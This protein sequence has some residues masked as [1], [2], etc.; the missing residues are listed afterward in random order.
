MR[1]ATPVLATFAAALAA[2]VVAA[3]VVRAEPAAQPQ[4]G[5]P[6]DA[7]DPNAQTYAKAR[8]GTAEPEVLMCVGFQGRKWQAVGG[9]QRPVHDFYTY[10]PTEILYPGDVNLGEFWDGVGS[11]TDAICVE[12]QMFSDGRPPETRSNNA[13]QYFG[14]T[15]S[16]TMKS[17]SLKGNCR[18]LISPCSGKPGPCTAAYAPP[19]ISGRARDLPI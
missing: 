7:A 14:F 12:E 13:G 16:P 10:G 2:A 9:L 8:Y 3:P 19:A 5:A 11:T 4:A 18:W 15:L 1:G 6:C 17:L